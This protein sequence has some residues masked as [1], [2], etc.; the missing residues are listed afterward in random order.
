[1]AA[2]WGEPVWQAFYT[3]VSLAGFVLTVWGFSL[4]REAPVPLWV[5][6]LWLGHV[7]FLLMLPVFPLLIAT[8]APGRIQAAMKH[9]MLL[10][11][12]LWSAAHLLANGNLA[13]VL[14]FGSF[15]VWAVADRLSMSRRVQ[16]PIKGMPASRVNDWVAVIL[17]LILYGVFVMWAHAWLFGVSPLAGMT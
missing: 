15:L 16:R 13:D 1:M 14:L 9:P 5:P 6:P 2:R 8:Y 10:A 4:T 7:T 17:G 11:A 3:V 12:I